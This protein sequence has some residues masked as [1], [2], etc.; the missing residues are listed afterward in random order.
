MNSFLLR[1]AVVFP[2]RF[3]LS[4]SSKDLSVALG[5]MVSSS[6]MAIRPIGFS[7]QLMVA[8]KSIPKSTI[9]HS[10]P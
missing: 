8:S 10:I 4:L 2:R 9:S 3:S 7:M 1:K 6:R 5:N